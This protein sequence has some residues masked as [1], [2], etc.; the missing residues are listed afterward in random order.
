MNLPQGNPYKDLLDQKLEG[1]ITQ[2]QMD[3]EIAKDIASNLVIYAYEPLP[4]KPQ[5]L[6]D[7]YTLSEEK[8]DKIWK[9]LQYDPEILK[10]NR[11]LLEHERNIFW[12]K[13]YINCLGEFPDEQ[14]KLKTRLA[15]YT[16]HSLG[17]EEVAKQWGGSIVD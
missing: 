13:Y 10:Y 15:Q 16:S 8:K 1:K 7:Y 9:N 2:S 6:M 11:I 17:D 3:I 12:L 14:L 5:K 4:M